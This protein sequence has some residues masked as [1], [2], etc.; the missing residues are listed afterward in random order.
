M[1]TIGPAWTR[2]EIEAPAGEKQMG[3]WVARVY[4]AEQQARLQVDESGKPQTSNGKDKTTVKNKGSL[5]AAE[6]TKLQTAIEAE[7]VKAVDA[8]IKKHGWASSKD[9]FNVLQYACAHK[10]GH[11]VVD[12][13]LAKYNVDV[14][15][16]STGD[17]WDFSWNETHLLGGL[18]CDDFKD[19]MD[20]FDSGLN[21]L[22]L[23]VLCGS[24]FS[25]ES[26]LSRRAQLGE[27]ATKNG[28]TYTELVTARYASQEARNAVLKLLV[29]DC[30]A[31]VAPK[32]LTMASMPSA[33]ATPTPAATAS[34]TAS[35]KA[36]F[37]AAKPSGNVE[38][39]L[40][41][42]LLE[43]AEV[44]RD[45]SEL[46]GSLAAREQMLEEALLDLQATKRALRAATA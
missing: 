16:A 40:E 15:A 10:T 2:G 33:A 24:V 35:S 31:P 19:E 12:H 29:P 43:L 39:M 11:G 27:L 45:R 21:C 18:Q 13:I 3:S 25:V 7:D 23:A 9:G 36:L 26:L 17:I 32:V 37:A 1:K 20:L 46:Q 44:K 28:R 6:V 4:T 38:K 42:A 8:L 34:S 22:H 14:A 5:S 41:E 30:R